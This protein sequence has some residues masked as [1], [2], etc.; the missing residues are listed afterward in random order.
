MG[1]TRAGAGAFW[2]RIRDF[3]QGRKIMRTSRYFTALAGLALLAGCGSVIDPGWQRE[4]GMT[5]DAGTPPPITLPAS[6]KRGVAFDATVTTFGS[7]SCTRAD[8]AEVSV[9]GLVAEITPYDLVNHGGIC[10]ADLRAFPRTVSLRFDEAGEAT[11]RVNG[12]SGSQPVRYET[13]I[14]VQP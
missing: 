3:I 1:V 7:G 13:R 9:R 11:V 4:V 10:T 14:T 2:V 5:G 12:R 6:A 8:G